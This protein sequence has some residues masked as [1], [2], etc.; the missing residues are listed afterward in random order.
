M[1]LSPL[2]AE[3]VVPRAAAMAF[4][5]AMSTSADALSAE[6][7]SVCSTAGRLNWVFLGAPGVGKGTYA[8]RVA[9]LMGVP[10]V[11]CG[12]LVRDEIKA[13]TPLAKQMTEITGRGQLLPDTLV[14]DL[15]RRRLAT[16]AAAGERGVLLD[17][18]PRTLAQAVRARM[19]V[20]AAARALPRHTPD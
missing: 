11:S 17:G 9:K 3:M 8:S 18:F 13:G 19:S 10:H 20:A 2:F 16:G 5:R 7:S 6:L 1:A 15:L 14:L 12:D 4:R